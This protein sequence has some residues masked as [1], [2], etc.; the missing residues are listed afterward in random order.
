MTTRD[1]KLSEK[2]KYLIEQPDNE[3]YV[4]HISLWEIQRKIMIWTLH[5]ELRSEDS[6]ITEP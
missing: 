6:I 5:A 1:E 2:T 4:S 3:V